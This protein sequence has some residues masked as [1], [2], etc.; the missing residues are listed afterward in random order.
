MTNSTQ[1]THKMFLDDTL[2]PPSDG[3]LVARTFEEF[4][5][6]ILEHGVPR[7]ISF[8]YDLGDDDCGN[9]LP[10]GKDCANWLIEA[11]YNGDVTI[12]V[13]FVYKVH[14]TNSP[15]KLEH[16]RSYMDTR[17]DNYEM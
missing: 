13:G 17:D 7:A 14:D 3:W 15:N 9:P 16:L 12:P 5:K 11:D 4:K 1:P 10:N 2:E 6:L 8:D